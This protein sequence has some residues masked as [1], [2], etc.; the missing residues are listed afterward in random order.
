L[1]I[2]FLASPTFY[3]CIL[4][5]YRWRAKKEKNGKGKGRRRRTE[6]KKEKERRMHCVNYRV[7]DRMQIVEL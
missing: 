6:R 7:E 2:S 1:Y 3:R 5:R 4:P